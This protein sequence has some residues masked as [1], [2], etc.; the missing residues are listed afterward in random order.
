MLGK[1]CSTDALAATYLAAKTI[2]METRD[3][4]HPTQPDAV[5]WSVARDASDESWDGTGRA[6]A[7]FSGNLPTRAGHAAATATEAGHSGRAAAK[8]KTISR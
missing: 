6:G 4:R 3:P 5:P 7:T 8:T 2:F 1:L